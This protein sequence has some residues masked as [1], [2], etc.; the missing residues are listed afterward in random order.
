MSKYNFEIKDKM[1]ELEFTNEL[2]GYLSNAKREV[3]Y[4]LTYNR[5]VLDEDAEFEKRLRAVSHELDE[6][7]HIAL[8]AYNHER[9]KFVIDLSERR[10]N[11]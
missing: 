9:E 7:Q 5:G 8:K 2:F 1:I 3:N 6:L 4:A 11:E 10:V